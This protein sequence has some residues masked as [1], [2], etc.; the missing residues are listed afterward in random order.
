[1][2]TVGTYKGQMFRNKR[3]GFGVCTYNSGPTYRGQWMEDRCHGE[4][5]FTDNDSSYTGNWRC[6]KKHGWGEEVWQ[7]DGTRYIGEHMGGNKH[8]KGQYVWRDGSC[9]DGDFMNDVVQGLGMLKDAEGGVYVGQFK[10]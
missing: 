3:W 10:D 9:Y 1:M 4:G 5:V 2:G 6:G 8:G 7:D